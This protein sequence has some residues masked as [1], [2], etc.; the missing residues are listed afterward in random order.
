MQLFQTGT[1]FNFLASIEICFV[2]EYMG[3]LVE[4][5][6]E[7]EKKRS[8]CGG[9]QLSASRAGMSREAQ[10][11]WPGGKD[12]GV[13]LVTSAGATGR[14]RRVRAFCESRGSERG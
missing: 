12:R 4:V 6:Q 13:V 11:R 9:F 10:V 1:I 8:W 3:H 7:T 5:P 2:S 14:G